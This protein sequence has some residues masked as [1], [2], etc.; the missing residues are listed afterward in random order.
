MGGFEIIK[1]G[2][3]D[4]LAR[5]AAREWLKDLHTNRQPD[6]PYCVALAGGRIA[7]RF[8]SE[9]AALAK[10]DPTPLLST[11][12]F[13]GDERCVPPADP[14]SNFHLAHENMLGPLNIPAERIHRIHGEKPPEKAAAEAETELCRLAASS[15]NG[16]PVLD[17]IFLGIGE[18]GHTAS[19]FPGEPA[20]VVASE[21]VYRAVTA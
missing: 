13:W 11:D 10:N 5:A 6:Q 14:E 9:V 12:F 19:L 21:R 18:E 17:L 7:G 3:P 15:V 16:Q 1:S 8:F 4:E 20:E 2:D